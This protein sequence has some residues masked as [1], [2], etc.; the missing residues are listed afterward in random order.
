MS[1]KALVAGKLPHQID[2]GVD[3]ED[4]FVAQCK[5]S[6]ISSYSY[7][8]DSDLLAGELQDAKVTCCIINKL[9]TK[10]H[11]NDFDMEDAIKDD[12]DR[13]VRYIREFIMRG[14][15]RHG[16]LAKRVR[17]VVS[18]D[19]GCC[20]L[21]QASR[22]MKMPKGAKPDEEHSRFVYLD[23][24]EQLDQNWYYLQREKFGL[25]DSIAIVKGYAF[26]GNRKPKGLVHGGMT[27][28]ETIIPNMEFS[29]EITGIKPIEIAYSGEGVHLGTS[30]QDISLTVRNLNDYEVKNISIRI[31]AY[32]KLIEIDAIPSVNSIDRILSIA[33]SRD[34]TSIGREN[35]A[36]L[37]A[38]YRFSCLGDEF[39]GKLDV[40]IKI[41]RLMEG[42][43]EAEEM[44]G[45]G[46]TGR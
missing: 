12:I 31:P 28:E 36:D 25:R 9:D 32:D 43:T 20:S 42:P 26:V 2:A 3:Y 37:V 39:N 19:H 21:P 24:E 13:W 33:L 15:Q 44:L 34:N 18:T 10:G 1:K 41:L 11:R 14:I 23:E 16:L 8:Q 40:K 4:L 7:I 27:P 22:G 6:S 29:L 17:V 30:A 45:L 38:Y 46:G 35:Y 5:A